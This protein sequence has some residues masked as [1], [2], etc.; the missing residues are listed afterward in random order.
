MTEVVEPITTT[1]ENVDLE[2]EVPCAVGSKGYSDDV[3]CTRAA[4]WRA[5]WLCGCA[6]LYC[7]EHLDVKLRASARGLAGC[8]PHHIRPGSNGIVSVSAL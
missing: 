6:P 1:L 4:R 2:L 8:R 3:P 5:A 7:Q